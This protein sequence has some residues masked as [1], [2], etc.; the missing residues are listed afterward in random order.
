MLSES[1]LHLLDNHNRIKFVCLVQYQVVLFGSF[2][3][4]ETKSL[5]HKQSTGGAKA[6]VLPGQV[7][8]PDAKE[9]VSQF[10]SFDFGSGISFGCLNG[11]SDKKSSVELLNTSLKTDA[12]QKNVEEASVENGGLK[13]SDHIMPLG[14]GVKEVKS[15]DIDLNKLTLSQND[16]DV[17]FPPLSSKFSVLNGNGTGYVSPV[18]VLKG[19][20]LDECNGHIGNAK[21]LTPRGL[22]N[23]GNLCFLN[24]TL[25]ALLSCSPF[26]QLLHE[27]KIRDIPEVCS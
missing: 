7:V 16:E 12:T 25:Q 27:L 4:D 17:S 8:K 10:G 3:E 11:E 9:K 13:G 23:S 6:Q 15:D 5:L 21:N 26:V 18:P 2:T 14:N 19:E 22:I 1:V 24:A 20:A